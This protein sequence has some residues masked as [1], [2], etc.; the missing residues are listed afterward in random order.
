MLGHRLDLQGKLSALA[1]RAASR[2]AQRPPAAQVQLPQ[3]PEAVRAVPNGFL[4]SSLFGVV[5][6]GRQRFVKK[7]QLASIGG[8]E[9]HFTGELLDQGDLTLFLCVLH[10]MRGQPLGEPCHLRAYSLLKTVGNTD[11]GKNRAVLQARIERLRATSLCLKQG[12]HT[13]IG[14]LIDEACR[15]DETGEWVI[16]MNPRICSLF[17]CDQFTQIDWTVRCELSG[18]PLAQWLHGFY[19]SHAEPFPL[20]IETLRRLC[21]S[22]TKSL[23]DYTKKLRRALDAV[24]NV[25]ANHSMDFNYRICGGLVYIERQ[26]S[27]TQRRHL[28]ARKPS[29]R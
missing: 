23:C 17:A 19:S 5:G 29:R 8:I 16:V 26:G 15:D 9:I 4:R 18:K 11:T 12:R 27:S 6:K 14:G 22:E 20:K 21:G 3:W 24:A 1:Q 10:E 28:K 25:S 2:D 13:Y 7:K